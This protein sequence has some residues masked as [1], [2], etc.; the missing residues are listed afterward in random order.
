MKFV[1]DVDLATSLL[2]KSR[3]EIPKKERYRQTEDK[4][5]KSGSEKTTLNFC[6]PVQ[7]IH[8]Q[9]NHSAPAV[10]RD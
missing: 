3:R 5:T 2:H 10:H 6:T 1:A 9:T 8:A 7:H 4:Q